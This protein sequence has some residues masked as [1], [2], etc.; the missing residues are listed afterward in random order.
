M[1]ARTCCTQTAVP[2]IV[3]RKRLSFVVDVAP[4]CL[5]RPPQCV[6]APAPYTFLHTILFTFPFRFGPGLPPQS[7]MGKSRLRQ[8]L[9]WSDEVPAAAGS[10]RTG[11]TMG[12]DKPIVN[13]KVFEELKRSRHS[14]NVAWN[15]KPLPAS[16]RQVGHTLADSNK[17]LLL[18]LTACLDTIQPIVY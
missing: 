12:A 16:D 15:G 13:A 7:Q 2:A 11:S 17:A 5:G 3:D 8:T 4:A 10:R 9:L 1:V 14:P 6:V 18:T